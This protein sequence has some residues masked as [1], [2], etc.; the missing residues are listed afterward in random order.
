MPLGEPTKARCKRNRRGVDPVE[1]V[2]GPELGV[3]RD[4]I[5]AAPARVELAA[6]IAELVDQRGLDVH[7]H[8]FAFENERK[9]PRL[10][11][12]PDFRQ[13]PHNLLAFVSGE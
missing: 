1:S 3:G 5:V 12:R 6:D 11:L 8:V 4:L 10:D 13:T 7:V 9:R 2:A